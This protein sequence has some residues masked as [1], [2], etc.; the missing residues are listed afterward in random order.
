MRAF[1]SR[2][3]LLIGLSLTARSMAE[4]SDDLV[5]E[6]SLKAAY[7]FHFAELVEWPAA[8]Q[9]AI[10]I[11]LPDTHHLARYLKTLEG[12][13]AHDAIVHIQTSSFNDDCQMLLVDEFAQ[14]SEKLR[15]QARDHHIL[16]LS[17]QEQFAEQGGMLQFSRRNDK[18][19]LVVN[20]QAVK[21]AGL[22][23]SSKL[24][25]MAQILE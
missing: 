1:F 19:N 25:R 7:V 6:Y 12:Q 11:C 21:Q 17:D 23:I 18:L 20:L 10:N 3:L 14:L 13:R 16:L 9:T 5:R 15:N 24:L 4:E 2:C 22:R 8:H